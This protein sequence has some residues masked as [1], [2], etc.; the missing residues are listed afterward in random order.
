MKGSNDYLDLNSF[1]HSELAFRWGQVDWNGT[2][3]VKTGGL[4]QTYVSTDDG[5]VLSGTGYGSGPVISADATGGNGYAYITGSGS[6]NVSPSPTGGILASHTFSIDVESDL[7]TIRIF[8]GISS[9]GDESLVT[10]D[11]FAVDAAGFN[12]SVPAGH[13]TF[14]FVFSTSGDGPVF[15]DTGVA[16]QTGVIYHTQIYSVGDGLWRVRLYNWTTG[17]LLWAAEY[18]PA[19]LFDPYD[20][21]VPLPLYQGVGVTANVAGMRHLYSKIGVRALMYGN[22]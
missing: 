6:V 18:N 15:F 13:T 10:T 14:Q 7:S 8:S 1:I 5:A 12:Y 19:N 21:T 17:E 2:T 20:S 22:F 16:F 3:L 4:A 9:A 11:D